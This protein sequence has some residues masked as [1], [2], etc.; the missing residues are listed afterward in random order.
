MRKTF[1]DACGNEV[2]TNGFIK[3]FSCARHLI[4]DYGNE[5]PRDYITR[6]G[7]EFHG[8]SRHACEFDVCPPCYNE[9]YGAA[10]QMFKAIQAA[11]GN[12]ESD[13]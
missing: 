3:T 13:N 2:E 11:N 5:V 6:V 1:C 12:S 4:Y 9:I 7:D 10:A 8:V